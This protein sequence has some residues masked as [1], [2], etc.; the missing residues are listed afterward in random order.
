MAGRIDPVWWSGSPSLADT[1]DSELAK[2]AHRER[3]KYTRPAKVIDLLPASD[4]A[5]PASDLPELF[6]LQA[7]LKQAPEA[8]VPFTYA[9][10]LEVI[11]L[12]DGDVLDLDNMDHPL[13]IVVEP[14]A[15]VTVQ[16]HS[17]ANAGYFTWIQALAESQLTVAINAMDARSVWDYLNIQLHAYTRAEVNLHHLGAELARQDVQVHCCEPGAELILNSAAGVLPGHHLDQQITVEHRAPQTLSRQRIHSTAGA[18]AKVTFNG[19]IHIHKDCPQVRA[20]LVNK[21]LALAESASINTK[22]EL[23]IYTDDVTCSH[24]ATV[25]ALDPA[26]LFY[27]AA[28]GIEPERARTML[29]L[30]FLHQASAGPLKDIA[31]ETL[32]RAII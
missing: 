16:R 30:A 2:P 12:N 13:L 11:R 6:D 27:C 7:Q 17:A 10:A 14:A 26:E 23:E 32:P 24:G 31:L 22:P 25:G 29:S 8:L 3:W 18:R 20:E 15:R 1:I 28:R 19:R 4:K 9:Q 5:L 21:N